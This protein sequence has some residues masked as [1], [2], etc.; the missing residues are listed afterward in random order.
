MSDYFGNKCSN[1]KNYQRNIR[2]CES[3]VHYTPPKPV[4]T[5]FDKIAASPEVL[6]EKLVYGVENFSPTCQLY[7]TRWYSNIIPNVVFDTKEEAIAATVAK[8]KEVDNG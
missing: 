4:Q 7:V 2:L 5:L 3:C 8:L 1:C 6:A